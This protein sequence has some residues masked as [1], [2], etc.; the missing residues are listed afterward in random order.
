MPNDSIATVDVSVE[1]I[2]KAIYAAVGG[3]QRDFAAVGIPKE[4]VNTGQHF[5]F[6]GIDA[7]QMALAPLLARHWVLIIPEVIDQLENQVTTRSGAATRVVVN[8]KYKVISTVDGS[9]IIAVIN[10][11]AI[12][13]GD[14]A[15]AKAMTM[16]FKTLVLQM[17]CV[18]TG[19]ALD[20]D[21]S[22]PE[23]VT[24]SIP[25]RHP[26]RPAVNTDANTG[27]AAAAQATEHR[28]AAVA[29]TRTP[30][31]RSAV[32]ANRVNQAMSR[33]TMNA[34]IARYGARPNEAS[35]RTM[36]T[37]AKRET[38]LHNLVWTGATTIEDVKRAFDA[39]YPVPR[40]SNEGVIEP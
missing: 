10:G 13:S 26:A 24:S 7:I 21:A 1:G 33:E 11:E 12:D 27:N 29:G 32:S 37:T 35:L 23:V 30:A 34:L 28:A 14:K 9:M 6:R 15:T 3:I 36:I 25:E 38:E 16:A 18:P 20:P 17:F 19:E 2:P 39:C 22:S 5:N 8:V 40:D 4:S 31:P